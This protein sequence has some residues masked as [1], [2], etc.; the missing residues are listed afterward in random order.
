MIFSMLN[1][2][3][4]LRI[5]RNP[6]FPWTGPDWTGFGPG[7]R[8]IFKNIFRSGLGILFRVGP[9]RGSFYRGM[10]HFLPGFRR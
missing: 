1:E 3:K 9:G 8:N 6:E 5:T 7:T 4:D 10:R 2:I